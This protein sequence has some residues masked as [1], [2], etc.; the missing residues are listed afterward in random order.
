MSATIA[1]VRPMPVPR[2]PLNPGKASNSNALHAEDKCPV[3]AVAHLSHHIVHG[4]EVADVCSRRGE[5][6]VAA[7]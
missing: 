4:D 5:D 6:G 3:R 7:Q 1:R 2:S